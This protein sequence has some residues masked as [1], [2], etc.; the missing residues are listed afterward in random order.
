MTLDFEFSAITICLFGAALA[1][2]AYVWAYCA[3][4]YSVGKRQRVADSAECQEGEYP[5]VSVIVYAGSEPEALSKNL[6][7]IMEQDYPGSF[8]VIV[9]NEGM[10]PDVNM[11][12][13][14]VKAK[15]PN[16]YLTFTPD[17]SRN[18][19]RRKLG[20]TIGIKAAKGEVVVITDARA[21]VA[22]RQWLKLMTSALAEDAGKEVTL[23]YGYPKTS[24]GAGAA[25]KVRAFD[26][27]ADA[28]TWIS[29]AMHGHPYRGCA[30]N[31]AYR[32]QLFFENKGF[33]GS[34]NM[35]DGD[36]DAF[37][38]AI[39]T[40]RNTALQLSTDAMVALDADPY[41][42]YTKDDRRSHAFTGKRLYKGERRI[43]A[44]GEWGIWLSA[45]LALAGAVSTGIDNAAGWIAAATIILSVLISVGAC[46]KS[47]LKAL[48]A[49]STAA[50]LP[51][52]A[53]MRPIRNIIV[54]IGS[55]TSHRHYIWE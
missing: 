50:L 43:M 26:M 15:Y 38:S 10:S 6:P 12:V 4:V 13:A 49:P 39:A 46:W 53:A 29:A 37:L 3:R 36:D 20:L 18:L 5:S 33:A 54:G 35:K 51:F 40:E 45:C 9:V 48:K 22:S 44:A 47:T 27:A 55:R 42:R 23:G 52:I 41:M 19:S 1:F 16:I 28:V 7:L 25:M 11:A 2:A 14:M 31:L 17:E 32:R 30:Y 21:E 24:E 34:I 8:E